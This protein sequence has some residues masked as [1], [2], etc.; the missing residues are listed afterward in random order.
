MLQKV[1]SQLLLLSLMVG[2]SVLTLMFGWGLHPQSWWWIIG[3][4]VF[5]NTALKLLANKIEE[6]YSKWRDTAK[7]RW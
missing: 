4:G 3:G 5:V 2:T 6:D 1:L 7:S